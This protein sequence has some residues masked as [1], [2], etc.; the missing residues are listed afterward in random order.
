[1]SEQEGEEILPDDV[2][3]AASQATN[4]LLPAK[5]QRAYE[6]EYKSFEMWRISKNISSTSE[7]VLMAYFCEKSKKVK[8]SSLW[9]YYSMLKRTLLIND[10]CDIS[11]FNKLTT[12]M[13]TITA[14]HKAKKSKVLEA[15]DILKFLTDAP[16][17]DY[18]LAK[19]IAI[20]GIHGATRSDELYKLM[21]S[22]VDDR[23]SVIVVSIFDTKTKQDRSFAVTDKE[24]QISFLDIIR[25]YIALRPS[26]VTH[27]KFFVNYRHQKCTCQPVGIN[28]IYKT[29]SK[30]AE[31]LKLPNPAM[32]TG[33]CFRRTSATLLAN[34]GADLVKIKR[35]G[36]WKSSSVAE[37][38]IEQSLQ[39]QIAVSQ[40]ILGGEESQVGTSN[41][42]AQQIEIS[43]SSSSNSRVPSLN[44]SSNENCTINVIFN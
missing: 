2:E 23:Q 22:N 19:V 38:Y 24:N 35:L 4:L 36:G 33:H 6:K 13:K 32:Y 26:T 39:T 31:F 16:D 44:I 29:P 8:P 37:T 42:S 7:K 18:L 15:E 11:K 25:K 41:N 21:I 27:N 34:R 20:F 1:M 5:S 28:T 3:S 9:S 43:S 10:N 30:I 17:N 12:F 14:G 40:S